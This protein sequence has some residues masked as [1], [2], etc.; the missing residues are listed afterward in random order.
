MGLYVLKEMSVVDSEFCISSVFESPFLSQDW[1]MY[2][3]IYL[4][5]LLE[6]IE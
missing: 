5:P 4:D 1:R 3:L 6:V 2:D